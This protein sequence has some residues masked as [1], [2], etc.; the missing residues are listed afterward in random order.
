MID[1]KRLAE[2]FAKLVK[3]DSVSREEK[4]VAAEIRQ[5]ALS[6]GA[7]VEE[8]GSATGTG[9]DTGNLIIRFAGSVAAPPLLLSAHMDTVEPGK[10]IEP[11]L[12]D[13]VFT[14][15]GNTVLG[16]DDKSAIAIMFEA[17]AVLQENNIPHGPI[18]MVITTC[19]EIGLQGAKHLDFSLLKAKYGYVLDT[20]DTEGIVTRAPAANRLSFAIHG[21]DAHAGVA[22]EN[23]INA[24][25]LAAKAI[26]SLQLGRID[27]E[28][29]CNIGQIQGGI[30][31]NIVPSLV[32]V[33]GEVR[34]HDQEVLDRVTADIVAAFQD[35]VEEAVRQG[36]KNGKPRLEYE[37]EHDFTMT[38]IPAEHPVVAIARKAARKSGREL[39]LKTTGGGADANI[40][41]QHGIVAG[42]LGTGMRDMHTVRESIRLSDMERTTQLL[43][44]II[45]IH[46]REF[47]S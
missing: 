43:I 20:S 28:T 29:T 44:D 38:N 40:F 16:A 1:T 11:V 33:T 3:I 4:A 10:G 26:A 8:D 2:R 6:L 30:A 27:A 46:T 36:A 35:A 45:T 18:E 19:E 7:A 22:P 9:S 32:T 24:I 47:E 17:V 37:V 39:A 5:M 15:A 14:S 23:G 25:H 31:T 13:G 21:K 34:G 42:V 12:R 41:F